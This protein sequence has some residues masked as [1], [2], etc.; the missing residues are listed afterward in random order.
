MKTKPLTIAIAQL[1]PVVGDIAA[2]AQKAR[3]AR[4]EAGRGGADLIVFSELFLAGYPPEDLVLKPAFQAACKTAMDDLACET[5]DNGPAMLIGAPCL[6]NDRLYNSVFLL[7]QGKIAAIRHKVHLPNY[8]VFDEVRVFSPGPLPEPARFRGAS[9]GLPICEDMWFEDIARHLKSAGAEIFISPNG[10]PFTRDKIS[11]RKDHLRKRCRETGIPAL[12]VNQLGGQDELVFDGASFVMTPDG[13]CPVQL[14]A[15]SQAVELTTWR[16]TNNLW[17]CG[18]GVKAKL[19]EQLESIWQA[20]VTG[21]RDY[22][23]KNRFP[24]VVLGLSGGID[25][26]VCAAMAVDALG[27]ERVHCI[28]LP[29]RYTSDE[30]LD[31]AARCARALGVPYDIMPIEP[32]VRGFDEMLAPLLKGLDTGITSENIQSRSRGT[33]LMALSNASGNMVVTT[34]NKSEMSVGYATLYGDM[35]GGFN[36]IKD[37]YKLEVFELARMRNRTR[38]KGCLGPVGPVMPE[39]IITKAPSAELRDNQ[40]DQDTLPPYE[41][42]D[43][44]LHSL[45]EKED[46]IASITARGHDEKTVRRIAHMLYIAEYKRRQAAPGVK[47]SSRNFGRGRRYPI[48]NGFRET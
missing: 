20:C 28:M 8:G 22:V 37:I 16:K 18:S 42:L 21:L 5:A 26:A 44:I 11:R 6:E 12:Y 14:P 34:G 9:L 1:D 30:S 3:S 38:P 45:I 27:A 41:I 40:K 29:Y 15:W 17:T 35:N 24:G 10:S 23:E 7:D 19:E 43:D 36:P 2:N 32:A 47:I 31:D 48:T 33:A 25:S 13:N 4:K 46:S 39:N